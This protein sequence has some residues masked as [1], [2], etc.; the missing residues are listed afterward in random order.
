MLDKI[1][2]ETEIVNETVVDQS[3]LLLVAG[4]L[5]FAAFLGYMLC[6]IYNVTH[7]KESVS[8]SFLASLPLLS[9]IAAFVIMVI[10]NSVVRAFGLIGA[11]SM[12]R[13]RTRVKRT[14][15]MAYIFMATSLGLAS[16]VTLAQL[17]I[18]ALSLFALIA[19]V[20]SWLINRSVNRH[21]IPEDT[22]PVE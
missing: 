7:K 19:L 11:I 12:V 13:F 9:V 21:N 1:F 10:G 3:M 20:T 14:I 4:K 2:S 18:V 16:G 17:S 6:I 5:L 15:E 22:Q 8:R